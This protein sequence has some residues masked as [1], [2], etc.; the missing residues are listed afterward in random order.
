MMRLVT[1][2]LG[3]FGV[4][5]R[6]YI[7]EQIR[8]ARLPAGMLA[9]HVQIGLI[10]QLG[11]LESLEREDGDGGVVGFVLRAVSEHHGWRMLAQNSR[12]S[13]DSVTTGDNQTI[14]QIEK[15]ERRSKQST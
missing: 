8:T 15:F 12:D 3:T 11:A 1:G 14:V 5:H 2:D 7:D 13:F 6:T 10:G 4:N 9:G